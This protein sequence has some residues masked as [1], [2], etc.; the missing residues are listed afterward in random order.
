MVR[1]HVGIAHGH[2]QA[3]VIENAL[4]GQNAAAVLHE[5]AG[6]GM[7]QDVSHLTIWKLDAR[8]E[9]VLDFV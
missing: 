6:K 1:G 3:G 2:G 5:V 4:Q 7:A 8:A 9:G